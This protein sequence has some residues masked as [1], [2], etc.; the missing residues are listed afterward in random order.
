[1]TTEETKKW[2][3]ISSYQTLLNKWRFAP[4]GD[5]MFQG[6]L[7]QY[8]KNTMFAKRDALPHDEQVRASKAVGWD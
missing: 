6:E 8:Y 5:P 1:M 3:D 4:S 2:I 7:G